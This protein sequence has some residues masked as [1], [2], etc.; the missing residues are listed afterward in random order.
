[1][2]NFLLVLL[3]TLGL[4]VSVIAVQ[5]SVNPQSK[6]G[7][8]GS[9]SA[10]TQTVI[11][12]T[13]TKGNCQIPQTPSNVG[14]CYFLAETTQGSYQLSPTVNVSLF[15]I[16]SFLGKK[17]NISGYVYSN[18]GGQY[19]SVKVLLATLITLTQ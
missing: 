5:R 2:K 12:G 19:P 6:A 11:T 18:P 16:A 17:V 13:I 14:V 7:G 4:G 1:M 3:I 15:T 8:L 10:P 9:A